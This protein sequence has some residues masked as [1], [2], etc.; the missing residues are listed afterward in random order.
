MSGLT[1]KYFLP[2]LLV[3]VGA[4]GWER[5]SYETKLKIHNDSAHAIQSDLGLTAVA[6]DDDC[7]PDSVKTAIQASPHSEASG[8]AKIS[9]AQKPSRS[10]DVT[11]HRLD[12]NEQPIGWTY[13]T[14]FEVAGP[15]TEITMGRL[16]IA[17]ETAPRDVQVR[18]DTLPW[19]TMETFFTFSWAEWLAG[20]FGVETFGSP[21][22]GYAARLSWAG[23][24]TVEALGVP[25]DVVNEFERRGGDGFERDG[26]WYAPVSSKEPWGL[27]FR[28]GGTADSTEELS[29]DASGCRF[30][31]S[32]AS[33]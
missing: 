18:K 15:T 33:F 2:L 27:D 20:A 23:D 26:Y 24:A 10:V 1:M 31:G 4:C 11:L 12:I 19:P 32:P 28:S 22:T 21:G 25:V 8:T 17:G 7:R 5:D 6:L 14:S 30:V 3:L 13:S 16:L 29:C 9:C